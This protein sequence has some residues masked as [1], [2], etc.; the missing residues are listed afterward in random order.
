[1]NFDDVTAEPFDVKMRLDN[2]HNK[3]NSGICQG[4]TFIRGVIY[5]CVTIESASFCEYRSIRIDFL[6]VTL[7]IVKISKN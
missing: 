3:E 1:M 5:T 2:G 6:S 7:L 4:S